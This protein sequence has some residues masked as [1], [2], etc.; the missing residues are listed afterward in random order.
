M[1]DRWFRLG[2][3]VGWVL[4][5]LLLIAFGWAMYRVTTWLIT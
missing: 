2:Y 4:Y 3:L 5:Y 1:R